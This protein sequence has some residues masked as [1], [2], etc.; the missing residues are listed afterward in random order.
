MVRTA[1]TGGVI[2]VAAVMALSLSGKPAVQRLI[3]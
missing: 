1:L 3:E 2:A